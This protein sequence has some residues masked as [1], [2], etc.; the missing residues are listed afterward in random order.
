M[1]NAV[2]IFSQTRFPTLN[3]SVFPAFERSL[4]ENYL[5]LILTNTFGNTYYDSKEKV[6]ERSEELH[7]AILKK[8]HNFMARA[9]VFA[10]KEG[11]MRLQP[12]FGLYHL[13]THTDYWKTDIFNQIIRTPNDLRDF[14]VITKSYRHGEGGRRIKKLVQNWFDHYFTNVEKAQYWALKYGSDSKSGYALKDII[15]TCH[16]KPKEEYAHIFKYLITGI[17]NEGLGIDTP[18]FNYELFKSFIKEPTEAFNSTKDQFIKDN[19]FPHEIVTPFIGQDTEMWKAVAENMPVMALLK[20]LATLERHDAIVPEVIERKLANK[21]VIEKSM[22][23]P[24]RFLDAHNKVQSNYLKDICKGALEMA[25]GNIPKILGR[26]AIFLDISGSMQQNNI[27][28]AA[29]MAFGVMKQTNYQ[30]KFFLFNH[31]TV[32]RPFSYHDSILSQ[33]EKIIVGG[34]TN[35]ESTIDLLYNKEMVFDNII[36]FTDEQQNEGAPFFNKYNRYKDCVRYWDKDHKGL[37]LFIVN[38][39]A[40]RGHLM[41]EMKD[42]YYMYGLSDKILNFISMKTNQ[43]DYVS[44][45]SLNLGV[46][47]DIQNPLES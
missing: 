34:N 1:S 25:M 29:L 33:V 3:A 16:V 41:N 13:T 31:Q 42:V 23:L 36:I 39:A 21:G 12:I 27:L 6:I 43:E 14:M 44:K 35:T 9:L 2:N 5:Q 38:V 32:E 4:E 15:K 22:I 8:D 20:N 26:S 17:L 19:K 30:S 46:A 18:I 47:A 10:R 28:T 37:K 11:Y 45:I 24:F 40:E 7:K